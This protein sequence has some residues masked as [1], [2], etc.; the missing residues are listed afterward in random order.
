MAKKFP[1]GRLKE[2]AA[3]VASMHE[4]LQSVLADCDGAED[5]GPIK[6]T[7]QS[8]GQLP[9]ARDNSDAGESWAD[10][11]ASLSPAAITQAVKDGILAAADQP[12]SMEK[13]FGPN[14][15]RLRQNTDVMHRASEQNRDAAT[16]AMPFSK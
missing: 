3:H 7:A 12:V 2:L 14:M 9:A 16:R 13:A 1:L 8:R 11:A 6:S 10:D 4:T 15:S 5:D